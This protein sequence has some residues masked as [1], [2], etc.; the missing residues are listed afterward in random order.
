MP[1]QAVVGIALFMLLFPLLLLR[2]IPWLIARSLQLIFLLAY[3]AVHILF[4][5]FYK[6]EEFSRKSVKQNSDF[7]Q[8]VER[9]LQGLLILLKKTKE[10]C[11]KFEKSAFQRKWIIENKK[12]YLTPLLIL[13]FWFIRPWIG[14]VPGLTSLLDKSIETWCSLEHWGMT[15][16]WQPSALT[17]SYPNRAS[18]WDNSLKFIEYQRKQKVSDFT[19]RLEQTP[20]NLNFIISRAN[21]FFDIEEYNFAFKDFSRALGFNKSYAPAYVG[22]GKVYLELGDIDKAFTEFNIAR[23]K[24]SKYAPAYV[25]RGDVYQRKNDKEAALAEYQKAYSLNH[26]YAPTY[27]SR[28][29][30]QCYSFGNQVEAVKD[31]NRAEEIYRSQGDPVNAWKVRQSLSKLDTL[32]KIQQGD[33]LNKIAARFNSSTEKIASVNS[34]KYASLAT[35]PDSIETGWEIRIPVCR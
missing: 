24:D 2:L 13:P 21:A 18:R 20:R 10:V 6:A 11:E 35:N 28:G 12:L 8:G 16:K 33:T 29:N 17:C 9:F 27:Y 22:K 30:L 3:G 25:G 31:Y 5:S 23:Q 4:W 7:L 26:Q 15:G 14:F 1:W 32:Y 19:K 34:D